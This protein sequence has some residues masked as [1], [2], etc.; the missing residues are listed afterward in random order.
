M[1]NRWQRMNYSV[2]HKFIIPC[3][4]FINLAFIFFV[5]FRL[6]KNLNGSL[7]EKRWTVVFSAITIYLNVKK[8]RAL[9]PNAIL[10]PCM[11]KSEHA[12][13]PELISHRIAYVSLLISVFAYINP[14]NH[15]DVRNICVNECAKSN[16]TR[17]VYVHFCLPTNHSFALGC[18]GAFL[19]YRCRPTTSSWKSLKWPF[20]NF[21]INDQVCSFHRCTYW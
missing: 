2:G 15:S 9:F 17:N 4:V 14:L 20:N 19:F 5:L 3:I 21:Y 1:H 6:I 13:M 11:A 12:Q 16:A 18:F 8:A 7:Q 10:S